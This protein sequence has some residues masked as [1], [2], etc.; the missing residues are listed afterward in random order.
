VTTS[1]PGVEVPSPASSSLEHFIRVTLG[2]K[3]PDEVFRSIA[4]EQ[5]GKPGDALAHTRLVIGNRLLIYVI[6]AAQGRAAGKDVSPLTKQGLADRDAQRLNRFRLVVA[7]T[8]PMLILAEANASFADVVG[9]DDRAHLHLLAT[10][11]LP[12]ELH[13][14]LSARPARAR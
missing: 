4:I 7:S 3:C 8:R 10:D 12:A 6:E 2:C 9:K 11:Q 13:P 5:V 14:P 1:R